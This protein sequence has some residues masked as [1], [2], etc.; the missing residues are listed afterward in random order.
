[1]KPIY[2]NPKEVSIKGADDVER[3]FTIYT[4]NAVDGAKLIGKFVAKGIP[5]VG[6]IEASVD[7]AVGML[8]YASVKDGDR[9]LFLT[10]PGVVDNYCPDPQTL[11]LLAWEVAGHSQNFFKPGNLQSFVEGF[12]QSLT[13]SIVQALTPSSP[14]SSEPEKQHFEN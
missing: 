2:R 1:M 5:S 3:V 6:D 10:T 11:A 12:I 13:Q 7:A 9:E 8:K 14:P 4:M